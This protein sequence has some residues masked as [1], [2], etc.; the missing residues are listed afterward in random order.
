MFA[1]I[2]RMRAP[3]PPLPAAPPLPLLS[4]LLPAAPPL[5]LLS[6]LLPA[7]TPLGLTLGSCSTQ[8]A[9]RTTASAKRATAVNADLLR[10]IEL[11]SLG[12]SPKAGPRLER[13]RD[14]VLPGRGAVTADGTT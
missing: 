6:P 3:S 7:A 2:T 13:R 9:I 8:P 12:S 5:P 4:P 1:L 11:S 14:G 10:V